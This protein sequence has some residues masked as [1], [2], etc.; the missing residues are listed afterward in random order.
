MRRMIAWRERKKE[1]ESPAVWVGGEISQKI[2]NRMD[3]PMHD[4]E[5][6][7]GRREGKLVGANNSGLTT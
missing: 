6:V 5:A 4:M 7:G 2:K 1:R 3:Q